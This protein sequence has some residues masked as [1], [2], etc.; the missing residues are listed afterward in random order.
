MSVV[1]NLRFGS[2][3]RNNE[4]KCVNNFHS[5]KRNLDLY[6]DRQLEQTN[7]ILS[8]HQFPMI[9]FQFHRPPPFLGFIDLIIWCVYILISTFAKRTS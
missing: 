5:I 9:V 8:A 7:G 3:S 2:P 1:T 6:L 4:I